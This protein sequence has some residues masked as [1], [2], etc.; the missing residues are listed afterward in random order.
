MIAMIAKRMG[1]IAMIAKGMDMIVM[2]AKGM[3]MI[4]MTAKGMNMIAMIAMR[5]GMND[6]K[7]HKPHRSLSQYHIS[8]LLGARLPVN[9]PSNAEGLRCCRLIMMKH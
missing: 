7:L 5:M 2:T 3:N 8:V 1:M 4:V 9:C 6:H